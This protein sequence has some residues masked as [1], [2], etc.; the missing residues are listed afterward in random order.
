MR[1]KYHLLLGIWLLQFVNYLDRICISVAAPMMMTSLHLDAGQLGLIFAIFALGYAVVQIPGGYLA[2]RFG[3]KA[4]VVGAPLLFSLFTG[5][6]GLASSIASLAVVRLCFGLAEGSCI[7]ACYKLVG[8]NFTSREG[9]GAHSIWMSAFAIGP[10]AVAPVVVWFLMHGSWRQVF[11]FFS[12][13][14][15]IVALLLLAM[16]PADR[17]GHRV[18]TASDDH[19]DRRAQWRAVMARK[20]TWLMF[21]GYL[22]FSIGYWGFLGWIP[23]YLATQRHIDLKSL[24]YAASIPYLFGFLGLIVF[25]ALGSGWLSRR[26]AFL[27]ALGCL[28]AGASLYFTFTA[29]GIISC[30]VG[31]S[32]SAF[33]LYGFLAP[34]A[35]VVVHLAPESGRG[36]F[37]A[38]V[39][40]GGQI[41]GLIAPIVIGYIVKASGSFDVG[42]MFMIAAL[43]IGAVCFAILQSHARGGQPLPAGAPARSL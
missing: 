7:A 26:R 14:G 27:L 36:V 29:H 12:I 19:G 38:F 11:F 8:D 1:H 21:F 42:F 22:T 9:A 34:Y 17:P 30:V 23:S 10:A 13:P 41:G 33:L 31:L 18:A 15:V 4:V 37:S 28:G 43:V 32:V 16:I 5:L 25:G 39:N 3:A 35:A 40:T 2:D 20:S 6:T 24:G